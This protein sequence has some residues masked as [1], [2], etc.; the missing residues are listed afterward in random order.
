[1]RR[2]PP[3]IGSGLNGISPGSVG[4]LEPMPR[5]L[6]A[7]ISGLFRTPP[8]P[9]KIVPPPDPLGHC[10]VRQPTATGPPSGGSSPLIPWG[11]G[12]RTQVILIPESLGTLAGV[13]WH[14]T[15]VGD[16]PPTAARRGIQW[17][18]ARRAGN[19]APLSS[20]PGLQ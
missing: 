7:D 20:P 4:T 5:P 11:T 14:D 3:W 6:A 17:G 2:K 12:V 15:A 18:F 19:P 10:Q 8:N 13:L 16:A 9:G 1:R